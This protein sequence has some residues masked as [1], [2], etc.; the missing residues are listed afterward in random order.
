MGVAAKIQAVMKKVG[1]LEKKGENKSQG[2]KYL[3]EEQVTAELHPAMAEAGLIVFPSSMETIENGSYQTKGGSTMFN[4]T[5]KTT[6][7]F[8]DTETDSFV[9][10]VV[11]GQGSDTGDKAYNKAMTACY[12]YALR[13]TFVISTGDDPDKESP[14]EAKAQPK[15]QPKQHF[16]LDC[17]QGIDDKTAKAAVKH[18]EVEVCTDCGRK[19]RNGKAEPA[20]PKA[21]EARAKI[22]ADIEHSK[23]NNFDH[24]NHFDN[25]LAKHYNLVDVD[26]PKLDIVTLAQIRDAAKVYDKSKNGE[27]SGEAQQEL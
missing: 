23:L 22:L 18:F 1:C 19:R 27:Q 10:V 26:L 8:Q 2:Y 14:Q 20:T 25:W 9:D 17:G 4:V 6:Y 5:L 24:Q 21:D 13:Q 15:G 7:R 3:G 12:K 16:C 11:Y